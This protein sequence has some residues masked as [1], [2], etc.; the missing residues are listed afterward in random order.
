ML[1]GKARRRKRLQLELR[2]AGFVVPTDEMA[3][4]EE[5]GGDV[6]ACAKAL[7]QA[8]ERGVPADWHAVLAL[9]LMGQDPVAAVERSAEDHYVELNTLRPGVPLEGNCRNGDR[10]SAAVTVIYRPPLAPAGANAFPW[11]E[12]FAAAVLQQINNAE[13]AAALAAKRET[14]EHEL[15]H[16]FRQSLDS[17]SSVRV[18]LG[19]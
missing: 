15:L 17:V 12:R 8:K 3:A 7:F 2:D 4:L 10:V 19:D 14:V 5:S 18:A 16:Y 13:S 1:F 9:G 11:H 6:E